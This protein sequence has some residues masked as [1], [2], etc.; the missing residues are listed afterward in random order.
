VHRK[1]EITKN[2]KKDI[3]KIK[4]SNEHYAKY[5]LSIA[6]LL[7]NQPLPAEALDH[8]LKGEWSGYRE[9]FCFF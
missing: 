4:F 7:E 9:C 1:I 2:F 3:S 6:K 8:Q 5:I